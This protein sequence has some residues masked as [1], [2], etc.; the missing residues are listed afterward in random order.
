MQIL[1]C[2][3]KIPTTIPDKNYPII[4]EIKEDITKQIFIF[5]K[6]LSFVSNTFIEQLSSQL[7]SH[8]TIHTG[9]KKHSSNMCDKSFSHRSNLVTHMTTHTRKKNNLDTC[10]IVILRNISLRPH[11]KSIIVTYTAAPTQYCIR[12][13]Y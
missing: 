1:K 10:N 12:L 6:K 13:Q 5:L 9:E 11:S 3:C 8:M 4:Q 2:N 7:I